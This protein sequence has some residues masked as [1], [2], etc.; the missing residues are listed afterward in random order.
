ML[1]Q[2]GLVS[3][4]GS[5]AGALYSAGDFAIAKAAAGFLSHGVEARHLRAWKQAAERESALFEQMVLPLLRQRNPQSRQQAATV[6]DEM[7]RHG[8]DLRAALL[9]SLLQRHLES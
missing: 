1:R 2:F 7:S 3:S 5:G 6:L 9:S 4:K 8:A